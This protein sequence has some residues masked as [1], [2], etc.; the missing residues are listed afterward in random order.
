MSIILCETKIISEQLYFLDVFENINW[1][2]FIESIYYQLQY[3]PYFIVFLL[4]LV[5]LQ[6]IYDL[7]FPCKNIVVSPEILDLQE[8]VEELNGQ[9]KRVVEMF[10]E[11][12]ALSHQEMVNDLFPEIERIDKSIFQETQLVSNLEKN[13]EEIVTHILNLEDKVNGKNKKQQ[14]IESLVENI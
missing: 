13:R 4:T 8:Q 7:I 10:N 5:F 12:V 6:N 9:L 2:S 3:F 11:E 14:E 1:F